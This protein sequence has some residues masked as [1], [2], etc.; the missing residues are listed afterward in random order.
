[1]RKNKFQ[2]VNI[3]LP[4]DTKKQ[5]KHISE[6][7]NIKDV[8]TLIVNSIDLHHYVLEIN[9]IYGRKVVIERKNRKKS[10]NK[11]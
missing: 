2:K 9:L 1:M 6:L 7:T 5:L 4:G 10:N 8:T 3:N 11:K